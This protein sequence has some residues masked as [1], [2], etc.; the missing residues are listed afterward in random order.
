MVTTSAMMIYVFQHVYCGDSTYLPV[1]WQHH[2]VNW[3]VYA[4]MESAYRSFWSMTP[5]GAAYGVSPHQTAPKSLSLIGHDYET[6]HACH[7]GLFL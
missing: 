5:I 4:K 7:D 6:Y 1:F 2:G 3:C